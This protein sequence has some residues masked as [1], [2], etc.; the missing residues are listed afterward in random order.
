[1]GGFGSTDTSDNRTLSLFSMIISQER[2]K[3]TVHVSVNGATPAQLRLPDG[4]SPQFMMDTGSDVTIIP[5]MHWPQTWSLMT[6][7]SAIAGI[8]G[9]ASTCQS[10]RWCRLVDQEEGRSAEIKP[11]V[12]HTNLWIL[13]RDVMSQWG[14]MLG[15]QHF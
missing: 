13:G 9:E 1:M 7:R 5:M 8:G 2:P 6:I 4:A 14:L 15:S 3:R 11:Y 10:A 12:M